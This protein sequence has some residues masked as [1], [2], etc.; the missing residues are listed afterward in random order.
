MSTSPPMCPPVDSSAS[1]SMYSSEL[2]LLAGGRDPLS[3][4]DRALAVLDK[5]S[6]TD[7]YGLRQSSHLFTTT[8]HS[9]K[10]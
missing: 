1:P 4:V 6:V 5:Q 9:R 8:F 2:T 3:E 7:M 10:T